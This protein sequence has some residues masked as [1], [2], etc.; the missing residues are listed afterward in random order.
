MRLL[1]ITQKIDPDDQVLAF[2]IGWIREIAA[3][4]ENL[5][6]LCLEQHPVTLPSNVTVWSMGK[7][8]GRNRIR[9]LIRFCSTLLRMLPH[10]DIVFTHMVPRYAVLAAPLAAIYRRPQIMWY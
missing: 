7:E 9:E 8:H 6:V 2:T 5:H 3:R 1:M 10:V 4:V